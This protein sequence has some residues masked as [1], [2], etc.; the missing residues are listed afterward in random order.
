MSSGI[1]FEKLEQVR[2]LMEQM[3]LPDDEL[4]YMSAER[5]IDFDAFCR[6]QDQTPIDNKVTEANW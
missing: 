3:R 6:E 1:T 4:V 5:A 2:A